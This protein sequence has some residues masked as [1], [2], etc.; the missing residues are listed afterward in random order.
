[1]SLPRKILSNIIT[2]RNKNPIPATTSVERCN[3]GDTEC[4]AKTF[5]TVLQK[6]PQGIP[7]LG[8]AATDPLYFGNITVSQD[9]GG[10]VS[11]TLALSDSSILGW[12][13]ATVTKVM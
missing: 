5:T 8:L 13:K 9:G 6:Y 1:M 12:S 3:F 11:L 4:L 10:P 2:K 7:E